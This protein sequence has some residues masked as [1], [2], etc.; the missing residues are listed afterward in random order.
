MNNPK[1]INIKFFIKKDLGLLILGQI[2]NV[3][4]TTKY[5]IIKM[6]IWNFCNVNLLVLHLVVF[7]M[8]DLTSCQFLWFYRRHSGE[9]RR[10]SFFIAYS[11]FYMMCGINGRPKNL[12]WSV[13]LRFSRQE[14][15]MHTKLI[16]STARNYL[17]SFLPWRFAFTIFFCYYLNKPKRL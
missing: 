12:L 9:Y 5:M 8:V 10:V 14:V 15:K 11:W 3:K 16:P 1:R 2:S 4:G 13:P 6:S 7:N 17:F